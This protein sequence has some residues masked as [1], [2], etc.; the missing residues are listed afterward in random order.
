VISITAEIEI[1][2]GPTFTTQPIGTS[3]CVG[4]I[5]TPPLSVSYINGSG[6]PQYQWY[7]N[8]V[9]NTT[10]GTLI[11]GAILDNYTTST[12]IAGTLYYYCNID[13]PQ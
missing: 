11:A 4:A 8:T 6:T 10:T 5:I 1:V 13:L 12:A 3:V 2:P 7:S 9:N